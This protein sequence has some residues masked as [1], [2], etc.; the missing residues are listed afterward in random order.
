MFSS[1]SDRN[2]EAVTNK[3]NAKGR[4][5]SKA[6]NA[7]GFTLEP[8]EADAPTFVLAE[9]R[10]HAFKNLADI[11][12][13]ITEGLTTGVYPRALIPHVTD[14]LANMNSRGIAW[15]NIY[16]DA[17]N[18]TSDTPEEVT[19]AVLRRYHESNMPSFNRNPNRGGFRG[20][21]N[22]NRGRGSYK[23]N[24]GNRGSSMNDNEA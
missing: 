23:G 9:L 21:G 18:L 2:I 19:K 1:I 5:T 10:D 13:I 17:L 8:E 11:Q 16:F 12:K 22:S 4:K 7:S 6:G 24:R 3:E 20:K 15:A 14:W